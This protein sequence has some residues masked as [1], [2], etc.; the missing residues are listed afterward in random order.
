M[1]RTKKRTEQAKKIATRAARTAA[2]TTTVT[3]TTAAAA[4][5][6]ARP[7]TYAFMFLQVDR[8]KYQYGNRL[9][10]F[11]KFHNFPG[12]TLDEQ[13]RHFL[14]RARRDPQGATR[15]T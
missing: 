3:A 7:V 11:F 2:T 14:E 6:N 1:I 4:D 8:T 13:G 10:S 9:R 5:Y 15:H 12:Q